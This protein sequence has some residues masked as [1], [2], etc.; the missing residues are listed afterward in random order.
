M[1]H[2][3]DPINP[4]Q[5]DTAEKI[6]FGFSI[7]FAVC[8]WVGVIAFAVDVVMMLAACAP[9]SASTVTGA[10]SSASATTHETTLSIGARN[11]HPR[12]LPPHPDTP[13]IDPAGLGPVRK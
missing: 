3:D 7:F 13:L 5:A 6:P 2:L 1:I 11:A 12:T 4:D 8:L 10:T 9:T